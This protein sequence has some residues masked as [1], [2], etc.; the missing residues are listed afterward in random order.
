M[1]NVFSTRGHSD[2]AWEKLGDIP[3]G[4]PNLGTEMP[5]SVYRIFEYA[6]YDVLCR[7]YGEEEANDI[8][9][10]AGFRAGQEFTNNVL[11]I[12]LD[13]DDFLA[14]LAKKLIDL[15]M[16]ILRIEQ[17][18]RNS[19]QFTLTVSEDLDCS[20]LPVTGE[21][22]CHYDEGFL[23]G[24]FETYTNRAYE[25]R[26]VDC[27]ATGAKACRFEGEIKDR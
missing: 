4:R 23:A 22:V 17:M 10:Q 26:E 1:S 11:D 9:R 6:M 25:V 15:K 3:A 27:W 24:I 16:G 12:T 7:K 21:V 13:L 20:G 2:F 8:V 14:D 5:V 19:G 18:D